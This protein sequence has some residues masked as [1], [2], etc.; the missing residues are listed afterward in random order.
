MHVCMDTV[1]SILLLLKQ[2]LQ[3]QVDNIVFTM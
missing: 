1:F 3:H 2:N